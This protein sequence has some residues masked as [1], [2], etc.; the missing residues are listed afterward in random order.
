MLVVSLLPNLGSLLQ[1]RCLALRGKSRSPRPT[2][3]PPQSLAD[4]SDRR[5][6]Q[7]LSREFLRCVP[8]QLGRVADRVVSGGEPARLLRDIRVQRVGELLGKGA[9]WGVE[10][11]RVK[12]TRS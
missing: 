10:D 6:D 3:K 5:Q 2:G 8:C 4:V 9:R 7:S 12:N 11:K 1:N